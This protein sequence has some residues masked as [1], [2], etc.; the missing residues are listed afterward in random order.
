MSRNRIVCL[1]LLL[2]PAGLAAVE[3]PPPALMVKLAERS[4]PLPV[5]RIEVQARIHGYLAETRMTLTFA[6]PHDRALEGELYFPLPEGSTLS[7][8]ALDVAGRMVDG[9]VV[10]KDRGR[11]VFEKIVRQGID[12]GLAEW[13]KGNNFRTRVFPIPAHGSRT[14]MVRYVT[15]LVSTGSGAAYHLPLRFRAPVQE[16]ALRV[17]AVKPS[18]APEVV[19]SAVPGLAFTPWHE[20]FVAEAGGQDVLLSGD[21]T[22]TVPELPRESV[23]VEKS[24][25]GGYYFVVHDRPADPRPAA[26]RQSARPPSRVTVLWDASGS[27][28]AHDPSLELAALQACLSSWKDASVAVDVVLFRN[29]AAPAKSFTVSGGDAGSVLAE[30]RAA[31]HDGGTQ[32]AAI[33]AAAGAPVPDLYLLFGDGLSNFG[34]H[35]PAG[36]EAPL[37]AFSAA[38]EANHAFLRS[39]ARRTG[40]DYFNLSRISPQDAAA[41]VGRPAFVTLEAREPQGAAADVLP[42]AGEP[43]RGR[44]TLAG[45][46]LRPD[47]ALTLRYGVA[48]GELAS[49]RVSLSGAS[50]AEGELLRVYWAQK[51]LEELMTAPEQNARALA[52]LGR[53]HSLVTPGTSLIVLESLEQYVEHGILPPDSLPEMRERY[54]EIL[55]QRSREAAVEEGTKLEHIAALWQKRVEW[56]SRSFEYPADFRWRERKANGRDVFTAPARPP[57]SSAALP[58]DDGALYEESSGG[59]E[60]MLGD[61]A[62]PPPAEPAPAEVSGGA[63]G[64]VTSPPE[65][66]EPAIVLQAW[67][68]DTPYLEAL[69]K[70][71]PERRFAVYIEQRKAF[72]SSPAFFLDCSD[73]FLQAGDRA[74]GLQVLSNVAEMELENAALLRILAHRLAQLGHLE[75]AAG[76]F[77]EVLRLRP[78]E[79]QSHRD[80]ALVLAQQEKYGRAMELLAHVVMNRWDRFEEIELIAL[81]ELNALIPEARAKGV[82]PVKLDPRLVKLLDV[83]VRIVI[84]WD[85][86]LTDIDL[87]VVEPSG[88]KA[89][90]QN[91]LTTIGGH[92]SRDFTQGYG[93]EEYMVRKA[94]HGVYKVRANFYGSQAQSL[95][96]AVTL[97]ADVFTNYGRPSQKRRSITLRLT[98]KKETI[99]VGEIEF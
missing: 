88:E 14:V 27:R 38:P 44:I 8:F 46:L 78:E 25:D 96:G 99:D 31:V 45:R 15:E 52:E 49:T 81:M 37:Y 28:A 83:D 82:E 86:D 59:Q 54:G 40:G 22:I 55:E 56:W 98:E 42:G 6:N 32:M 21:L 94:M 34:G 5:S 65:A 3:M 53:E 16:L 80:L 12:P 91:K 85:A 66:E 36:L 72:G 76:L 51:K 71:K 74:L 17:E 20:S 61:G 10:T 9:V 97:Q 84:T 93:P 47:A 4:E 64:S 29:A 95:S 30:L 75:L 35:E 57:A 70:A 89:F 41:A 43:V 77:E 48:G 60:P 62:P 7:G 19:A 68:P 63:G 58:E 26:E 1:L 24:R 69:K 90:Y 39:L 11:Q 67:N 33:S 18:A 79:P 50:A 87:W 2:A 92:F 73:F 23:L 13:T